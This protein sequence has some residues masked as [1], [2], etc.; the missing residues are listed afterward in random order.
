MQ[1]WYVYE[2]QGV[3][4]EHPVVTLKREGKK[5]FLYDGITDFVFTDKTV[6]E[7]APISGRKIG[8]REVVTYHGIR[9]PTK[10]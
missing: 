1:E 2:I 7:Y 8:K 5:V 3:R 10:Y 4:F 9:E 6:Q